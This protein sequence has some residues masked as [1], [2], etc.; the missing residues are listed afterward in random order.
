MSFIFASIEIL[1][2]ILVLN[3]LVPVFPVFLKIYD[4]LAISFGL[5]PNRWLKYSLSISCSTRGLEEQK[6]PSVNCG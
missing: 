2:N 3:C 6:V 1:N 5:S 4:A